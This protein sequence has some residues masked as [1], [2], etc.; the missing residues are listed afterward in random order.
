VGFL[1]WLYAP[2]AG[3]Q[4]DM[5]LYLPELRT[6]RK[7]GGMHDRH[8]HH[9][10]DGDETYKNSQLDREEL[11]PR[12]PQLDHHRLLGMDTVEGLACYRVEGQPIDS[13]TSA[14]GRRITWVTQD[15]YLPVRI[16]YYDQDNRL[17]KRQSIAWQHRGDAWFWDEVNAV[18]IQNGRRTRLVQTDVKIN[19]DLP[20]NLFTKRILAQGANS[21]LGRIERPAQ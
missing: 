21:L 19:S 12:P 9:D 1:G 16:E 3:K 4:D 18:N 7:M 2:G 13:R 11:S 10:D 20:D 6:V 8:H 14:Y 17:A 15:H 5:W